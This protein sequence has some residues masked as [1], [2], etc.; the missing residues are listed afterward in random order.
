MAKYNIPKG[1][2]KA[3]NKSNFALS[4]SRNFHKRDGLNV[5]NIYVKKASLF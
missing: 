4:L 2:I 1:I 5:V 3:C